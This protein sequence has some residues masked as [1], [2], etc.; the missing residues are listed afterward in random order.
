MKKMIESSDVAIDNAV[1][2]SSIEDTAAGRVDNA[3][4]V[5]E[6]IGSIDLTMEAFMAQ[7]IDVMLMEPSDEN[8]PQYAEVTVNGIYKLIP[9]DGN[10]YTIPRSHVE[11]LCNAKPQRISQKKVVVGDEMIYQEHK[12]TGFAYPFSVVA[13]PSGS[14]GH[15]W[16]RSKLK[17][18][19]A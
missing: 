14:R 12:R 7:P 18:A 10:T 1:K 19:S 9:R 6:P 4:I 8:E 17:A 2:T 15:E 5:T 16:L 3:G 13:D 11:A